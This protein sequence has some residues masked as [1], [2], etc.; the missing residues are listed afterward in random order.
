MDFGDDDDYDDYG[1]YDDY[2]DYGGDDTCELDAGGELG[3]ADG[4]AATDYIG[5]T[6]PAKQATGHDAYIGGAGAGAGGAATPSGV[7][8]NIVGCCIPCTPAEVGAAGFVPL[9][10]AQLRNEQEAA[11]QDLAGLL[12]VGPAC[13][14][15]LLRHF[16]WNRERLMD[17]Y[18][19]DQS[20]TL[21]KAGV[22]FIASAGQSPAKNGKVTCA[23]C[24]DDFPLA[25]A[26]ATYALGCR[27]AF[28]RECWRGYLRVKVED[29]PDCI[30]AKCP[31]PKC[32]EVV[33]QEVYQR[34]LGASNADLYRKYERFLL[35]SF[36]DLSKNLRWCPG[37]GCDLAIKGTGA[38][39]AVKCDCG[40]RFCFRCAEPTH[41]PLSCA[42]LAKWTEKCKQE[43]TTA[44]WM[45]ENTKKCPECH[46]RIEKNQGCNHMVCPHCQH[47]FCWVCL[48]DWELHNT[49]SVYVCN[50]FGADDERASS[51]DS[52]DSAKEN[53]K[54][55]KGKRR[56]VKR[57]KDW[58]KS[59]DAKG[60]RDN[61]KGGKKYRK[62][63]TEAEKYLHYYKRFNNHERARVFAVQLL[64]GSERRMEELHKKSSAAAAVAGAGGGGGGDG[65]GSKRWVDVQYLKAACEL[66]VECREVLAYSYAY[67][68]YLDDGA[69]EKNEQRAEKKKMEKELFEHL[70]ENVE[71]NTEYL[72]ELSEMTLDKMDR[73][74]MVNFT[75]VTR[76]FLKRFLAGVANGLTTQT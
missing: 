46:V 54:L 72:S 27:H 45:L 47:N 19:G 43:A 9:N 5:A 75:T 13:A 36:V 35:Q 11:V 69:K 71:K 67:G 33:T 8:G 16:K 42:M 40:A 49:T 30:F 70:Q 3:A 28:C 74:Q 39:G 64:E 29:G 48:Q 17:S 63:K 37:H 62:P 66:V 31:M 56:P 55:G 50:K 57:G 65:G 23:V 14:R 51:A 59:D 73:D 20:G 58:K 76:T 7:T 2:G 53:L 6:T 32:G 22:Q 68:Y 12:A 10:A 25:D 41:A 44:E 52:G 38:T 60:W 4:G 61:M 26:G 15:E 18:Y 24:F 1:E 34:I 21:K